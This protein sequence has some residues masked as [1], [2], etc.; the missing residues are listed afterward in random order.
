[1]ASGRPRAGP[2]VLRPLRQYHRRLLR[3]VH[4]HLSDTFH[5]VRRHR[6]KHHRTHRRYVTQQ[7]L[8]R[9]VS[10]YW[11]HGPAERTL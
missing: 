7:I 10:K 11:S 6:G 3:H 9:A 8:L 1:M 4:S 2:H 5:R